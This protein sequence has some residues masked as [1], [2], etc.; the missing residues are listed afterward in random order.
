[1]HEFMPNVRHLAQQTKE[2]LLGRAKLAQVRRGLEVLERG[3]KTRK[4]DSPI[5]RKKY[6]LKL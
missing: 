4:P 1:M 3:R 6:L 2:M 5:L